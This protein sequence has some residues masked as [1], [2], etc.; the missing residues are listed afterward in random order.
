MAR[1][2]NEYEMEYTALFRKRDLRH[3]QAVDDTLSP[4]QFAYALSRLGLN[5]N[6]A[7]EWLGLNSRQG[8]RYANG[9]LEI[10]VAVSKLVTLMMRLGLKPEQV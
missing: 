2:L 6:E 8:R 1:P 7:G 9:E 5:H 3:L 4:E 10:P